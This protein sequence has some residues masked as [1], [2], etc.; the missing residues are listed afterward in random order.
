VARSLLFTPALVCFLAGLARCL[1]RTHNTMQHTAT[2][3]NTLQQSATSCNTLQRT[4]CALS[5]IL[6]AV[7]HAHIRAQL[8]AGCCSVLQCVAVCCSALQCVAACCS[9]LQRV[10]L[11]CSVLHCLAQTH[12]RRRT[13]TSCLMV[14]LNKRAFVT[15]KSCSFLARGSCHK[16]AGKS[17]LQCVAVCCSVLQ[18][19]AV[20]THCN[21]WLLSQKSWKQTLLSNFSTDLFC[22]TFATQESSAVEYFC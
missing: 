20:R 14:E 21:S 12:A 5:R 16:R 1:A 4:V 7:L 11:S 9:V 15:C 8:I 22:D 13:A 3:C 18:C 6:R 17:V 2:H 10:A 19:V